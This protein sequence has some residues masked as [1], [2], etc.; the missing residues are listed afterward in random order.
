MSK[1]ELNVPLDTL[2]GHFRDDHAVPLVLTNKKHR[3]PS[4]VFLSTINADTK[5]KIPNPPGR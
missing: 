4:T 3:K 1:Y 2:T 5:T